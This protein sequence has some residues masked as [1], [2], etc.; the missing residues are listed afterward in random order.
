MIKQNILSWLYLFGA[1]ACEMAWTY[2]LKYMR[3]DDLKALRWTTFYRLDGG[4]PALLPW[5]AYVVFGIVNTVMLAAAMRTIST[6]TAFAVW[7][8]VSL[9]FIKA[10]DVIWLKISWSWGELFFILLITVGII[11]LRMVGPADVNP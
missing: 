8:A 10:A 4:M 11:G 6:T 2:S 7:M 3:W 9:V 1:A 5:I